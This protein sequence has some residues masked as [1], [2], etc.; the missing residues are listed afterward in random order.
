MSG[1]LQPQ[2]LRMGILDCQVCVP[3]S[4]TDDE[5]R[6]F[7]EKTWPCGTTHGWQ[8]RTSLERL[9]G[10]PVRNPCAERAGAVHITLE[11]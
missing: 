3:E 10:H 9:A 7:A 8:I 6:A 2:G 4:F 5:V 11:A 1:D